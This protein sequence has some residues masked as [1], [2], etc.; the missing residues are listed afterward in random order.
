MIFFKRGIFFTL[1]GVILS[2]NIISQTDRADS[3]FKDYF[4]S[5]YANEK[6]SKCPSVIS[7]LCFNHDSKRVYQVIAD[8]EKLSLDPKK[9]SL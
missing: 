5:S 3:L 2:C 1:F 4:K 8:L 9:T 7:S 6:L